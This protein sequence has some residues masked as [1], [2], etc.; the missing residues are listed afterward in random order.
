MTNRLERKSNK[1]L[2]GVAAGIA[3]YFGLDVTIVR[4]ILVALL[5]LDGTGIVFFTYLAAVWLMPKAWDFSAA[6]PTPSAKE[7]AAN[8][9][10]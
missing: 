7:E 8:Q 2:F 1:M 3:D 10:A 5:C 6:A 9:T 4:L